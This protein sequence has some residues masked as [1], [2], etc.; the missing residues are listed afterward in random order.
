[1]GYMGGKGCQPRIRYIGVDWYFFM[2]G[3]KHLDRNGETES[4]PIPSVSNR[5]KMG[6]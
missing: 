1:M 2:P 5:R 6:R 3:P 4:D